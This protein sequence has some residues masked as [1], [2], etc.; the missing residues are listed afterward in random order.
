MFSIR[1]KKYVRWW[2]EN[3][4]NKILV[5]ISPRPTCLI[6]LSNQSMRDKICHVADV[7]MITSDVVTNTWNDSACE[8]DKTHGAQ[9]CDYANWP[10]S[11]SIPQNIK[12]RNDLIRKPYTKKYTY[13]VVNSRKSNPFF[14]RNKLQNR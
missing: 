1:G 10:Y 4:T 7:I 13:K 6:F 14:N 2:G 12:K 8:N 11:I 9:L 3:L 5:I